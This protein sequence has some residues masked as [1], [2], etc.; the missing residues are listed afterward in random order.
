[1][2]LTINGHS[3]GFLLACKKLPDIKHPDVTKAEFCNAYGYQVYNRGETKIDD[4]TGLTY[5]SS[6]YEY[7]VGE[8]AYNRTLKHLRSRN[9][10]TQRQVQQP[11]SPD[12]I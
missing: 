11:A 4:E 6:T 12:N 7:I 2:T 1:M 8:N 9:A 3:L 5:D 10:E